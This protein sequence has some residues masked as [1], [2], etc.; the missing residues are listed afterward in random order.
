M[1]YPFT[2]IPRSSP[3]EESVSSIA[4]DAFEH[5]LTCSKGTPRGYMLLRN[6]KV[7][8]E[9][10]W[11]PYSPE[12][13]VWVYSLS[14]S[15]TATAIG[16]AVDEGLLTTQDRVIDFFEDKTPANIGENLREMRIHHLLSMNTGHEHEPFPPLA[17]ALRTDWIEHFL[18]APVKFVPGDHFLYNSMASFMLSA[19]LQK[20]SGKS[21]HDYLRMRLFTPLGFDE[22]F[23]D[24]TPQGTN[25]GGWGLM[26]RLEDAAKL[27][28]LYL[29]EGIYQGK[30]ILSKDWIKAATAKQSVNDRPNEPVD[31]CQGYGYQFWL[32][33]HDAYRGDGA[34]GQFCVVMPKQNMVLALMSE[35]SDMQ[36]ILDIVWEQLL[37]V[38]DRAAHTIESELNGNRYTAKNS[39]AGVEKI[40]FSFEKDLLRV[41]F[42]HREKETQLRCGRGTWSEGEVDPNVGL[43][44]LWKLSTVPLISLRNQMIKTSAWFEWRDKET[45]RINI[46]YLETPHRISFEFHFSNT[47]TTLHILPSSF[48]QGENP[49]RAVF[50]L[51]ESKG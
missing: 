24:A 39:P 15:F 16:I 48:E 43:G 8:A 5:A 47:G 34:F 26:V 17:E 50:S 22:T 9:R 3:Q 14:K 29:D 6:G 12:N 32:C 46:A 51:D 21:L 13:K 45:L 31:W 2:P 25:T 40:Q 49:I 11:P 1:S 27:G 44:K 41:V 28:Q 20:V 37:P 33:R 18:H 35:T 38:T 36:S 4:I 30:T 7:I 19:I 10:F 42:T 23:W